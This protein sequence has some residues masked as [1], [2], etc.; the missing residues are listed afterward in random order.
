M[1]FAVRSSPHH[2]PNTIRPQDD[3]PSQ[4]LLDVSGLA[5]AF[6]TVAPFCSKAPRLLRPFGDDEQV[7]HRKYTGA[8]AV[9]NAASIERTRAGRPCILTSGFLSMKKQL[10]HNSSNWYKMTLMLWKRE[11]VKQKCHLN[12]PRGRT[13]TGKREREERIE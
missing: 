12:R 8:R 3:D 10:W 9:V 6:G 4:F 13:E 1:T 11:P 5:L 7:L 2:S